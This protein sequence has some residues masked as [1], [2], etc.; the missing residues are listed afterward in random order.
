MSGR[1]RRAALPPSG[2]HKAPVLDADGLVLRPVSG[3]GK[4]LGV[5]DFRDGPGPV[6]FRRSLVA[7][8]A[9]QGRGWGS[10]DTYRTNART[11]R[12]FLKA[13]AA[14]EPPVTSTGQITVEWWKKWSGDIHVRRVL[15]AVVRRAPGVP[16]ATRVFMETPRRRPPARRGRRRKEAHTREELKTIRTGAAA[17]VRAGR[18]RIA[19]NTAVLQRWRAGAIEPGDGDWAVGEVLDVLARTG[20]LPRYDDRSV[21]AYVKGTFGFEGNAASLTRLFA[22][23]DE[24]G[25]AAV[26][27]I[28][29]EAWNLSVVKKMDVPTWWPNA[30]RADPAVHQVDTDKARRGRRRYSSNTLVD[31]GEG[32]GGRALRHVLEL[33]APARATLEL[34]GRPTARLLVGHRG[35]GGAENLRDYANG[36]VLDAAIRRWQSHARADGVAL[37]Q[38]IHAQALRHSAQAHHG[39]ARN[40]TQATHERDYQLL[41]EGVRDA[42]RGAVELGLTQALDSARQ[43]VAMRLVDH[44][45][46]N[47]DTEAGAELVAKEAEVDIEVARR[48]VAGRLR[49]PVASCADFLNSDHSPVGT[50][51]AVSFLLCFACRNAVATGRD[52]PR[53]AYLHQAVESLRS[54]VT[55]GVWAAD[56]ATHHARIGDFLTTYT[57]TDSR[58]RLVAA[59]SEPDRELIHAMLE[60]RLD[61]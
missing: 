19:A 48:I 58:P 9:A 25:A 39:R 45:D 44:V 47:T 55:P 24:I 20:D 8:L 35:L 51:C 27:L 3:D 26:L 6:D 2:F 59:V 49:T 34:L 30:D 60:R 54:A 5:W 56:W 1:G 21:T 29:H 13:A 37:P 32:S 36:N 50:P 31:V 38:R 16:E 14:A 10:E 41:D 43:T 57:T 11:L 23:P 46:G 52:L 17:T 61:P 22:T 4:P 28:V 18:L 40:N 12:L 42:S 15:A 33:T 7:A 53:I